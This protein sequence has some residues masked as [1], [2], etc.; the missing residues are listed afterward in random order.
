MNDRNEGRVGQWVARYDESGEYEHRQN[1]VAD[2][3]FC[4]RHPEPHDN[5]SRCGT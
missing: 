1:I 2:W 5:E 4:F 3:V